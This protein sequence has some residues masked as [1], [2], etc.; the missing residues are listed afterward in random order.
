MSRVRTLRFL[1][2]LDST[3]REGVTLF[4]PPDLSGAEIQRTIKETIK[5][6]E[7]LAELTDLILSSKTGAVLFW[8]KKYKCL[9]LPPFPFEQK[10]LFEH[11]SIEPLR[12]LLLQNLTIGLIFVRL[13][14]FAIGVFQGE[15][16]LSSK[17]GTGLVHSRHKKGGSSQRR[18]ER[19]RE[20]QMESF[21]TRV[22]GH[23]RTQLEPH[24]NH[25][26]HLFY[27]GEKNTLRSF[28]K[29]CLFLKIF[30]NCTANSFLNVRNPRRATLNESVENIWS[31]TLIEW[32]ET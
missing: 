32:I 4:L 26:V 31:S 2:E 24:K 19:H 18:F 25:I 7:I 11:Y 20:K 12:S 8:G 23:V 9:I 17:T 3:S 29:Q 22:C 21:F 27:G 28:R 15:E 16:L 14:E 5:T 30:D 1:E 10:C 13:G 6:E